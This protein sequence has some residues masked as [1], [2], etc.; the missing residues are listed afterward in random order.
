MTDEQRAKLD[1]LC[2]ELLGGTLHGK[3][4]SPQDQIEEIFELGLKLG[5]V[6]EGESLPDKLWVM[7]GDKVWLTSKD[8]SIEYRKFSSDKNELP[9]DPFPDIEADGI[10]FCGK[11]GKEKG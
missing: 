6:G 4:M 9:I 5:K 11:C 3:V 10:E 7:D 8:G 2:E 1:S